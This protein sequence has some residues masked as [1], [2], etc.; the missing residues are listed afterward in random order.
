MLYKKAEKFEE[1]KTLIILCPF[2]KETPILLFI[3]LVFSALC[4]LPSKKVFIFFE[5][6]FR[7]TF[8]AIYIFLRF[9]VKEISFRVLKVTSLLLLIMWK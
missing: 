9:S 2:L 8:F 1:K 7:K 5:S 3:I 4:N 6:N